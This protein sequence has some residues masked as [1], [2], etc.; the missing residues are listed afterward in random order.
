[1]RFELGA[2]LGKGGMAE[3]REGLVRG[4]HG[5]ERRVA[6]KSLLPD[7]AG[8]T[9]L[10]RMF[11]DEARIASRL[12]HAGIVQVLDY[13]EEE[14]GAYQVL[15]LVDGR[16]AGWLAE[17]GRDVGA[18]MPESV[19]LYV[20]REVAYALAYAHGA[21]DE[22]GASLDIVHRDVKPSNILV[23]RAG[24]I[25]LGDFGIARARDRLTATTGNVVRGTPGFMSPEQQL[26]GAVG[27]ASDLF[28][29][30]CT[31]HS[32]IAHQS[33]LTG[34]GG[35]SALLG[36]G[37]LPI[38]D[39]LSAE[40]GAIVQRAIMR[41]PQDRYADASALAEALGAVLA[42]KLDT[43]AKSALLDWFGEL[44]S[45]GVCV[46]LPVAPADAQPGPP[47]ADHA[48]DELAE[49]V[50]APLQLRPDDEDA[51]SSTAISPLAPKRR[52]F[53]PESS[54]RSARGRLFAFALAS[55]VGLA[56]LGGVGAIVGARA[57]RGAPA[58]TASE[59]PVTS[60]TAPP[61]GPSA[62]SPPSAAPAPTH[63]GAVATDA[64][65]VEAT[66]D[67][68]APAHVRVGA[69]AVQ[70]ARA[71]RGG[72]CWCSAP[73]G[74]TLCPRALVRPKHT[75]CSC[76]VGHTLKL[77][78]ADAPACNYW[79]FASASGLGGEPC[80]GVPLSGSASP[81]TGVTHCKLCEERAFEGVSRA[82]CRGLSGRDAREREGTLACP[83]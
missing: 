83:R 19:A 34:P 16:D 37:E 18:P 76:D 15:E 17:R 57:R 13:G 11:L 51:P 82:P 7:V 80:T 39:A 63:D 46:T 74:D 58:P 81:Q 62:S 5:F 24:D 64:A 79:S 54:P 67:A 69:P 12:H 32:L 9:K 8:D 48:A 4:A 23:S 41:S 28:S 3:V 71:K 55:T 6:I 10:A 26:G 78:P 40:V 66:A 53:A 1:M 49:T 27:P 45:R 29:L 61:S 60:A 43:D 52:P 36:G 56:L 72:P 22:S 31:L 38:S 33:P 30:G 21:R 68:R 47:R 2:P 20:A 50:L 70:W 65:A 44:E 59:S 14:A 73:D 35:R 42:Q 25:K 77:C 75:G